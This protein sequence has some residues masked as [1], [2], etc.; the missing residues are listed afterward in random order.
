[1]GTFSD[2]GLYTR[3]NPSDRIC[4]QFADQVVCKKLVEIII[5]FTTQR[6]ELLV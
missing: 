3:P 5:A 1:M 4:R 2:K 6:T